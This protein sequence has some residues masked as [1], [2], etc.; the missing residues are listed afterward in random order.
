[1]TKFESCIHSF[2]VKRSL[3][4]YVYVKFLIRVTNRQPCGHVSR[5]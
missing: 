1:M 5:S 2:V 3:P 4:E